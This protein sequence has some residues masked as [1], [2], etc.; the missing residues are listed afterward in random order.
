MAT[1]CARR[2]RSP[3]GRQ[4]KRHRLSINRAH[5]PP[6]ARSP[7]SWSAVGGFVVCA[8][9]LRR[10]GPAEA[11]GR[12][13]GAYWR[14]CWRHCKKHATTGLDRR[15]RRD[16]CLSEVLC[17]G[18]LR[19]LLAANSARAGFHANFALDVFKRALSAFLPSGCNC[20]FAGASARCGAFWAAW[21]VQNDEGADAATRPPPLTRHLIA[22]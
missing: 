3:D 14:R 19:A 21:R 12:P 6:P 17:S 16:S 1:S 20:S 13:V 8:G 15:Q 4:E 7:R 11:L 2:S 5:Q 9:Y 22:R 18:A 10:V